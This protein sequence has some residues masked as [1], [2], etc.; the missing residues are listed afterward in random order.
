MK[1]FS[2]ILGLIVLCSCANIGTSSSNKNDIKSFDN[3]SIVTITSNEE[4]NLKLKNILEGYDQLTI[5]KIIDVQIQTYAIGV[6]PGYLK[7]TI[8]SNHKDDIKSIFNF[9]NNTSLVEVSEL[10]G[11]IYGGNALNYIISTSEHIY[12]INT[13]DSYLNINNKYYRIDKSAYLKHGI[14]LKSFQTYANQ[15][16]VYS[17]NT[18]LYTQD[19]LFIDM[20][21]K[22]E[23][24]ISQLSSKFIVNADFG[25]CEVYDS[26]HFSYKTPENK[27]LQCEII[28]GNDFSFLFN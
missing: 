25:D 22:E 3:S 2:L 8:F 6:Q 23:E 1:K 13:T 18:L 9:I 21:F 16:N 7:N 10:E 12:T 14:N 20:Y 26:K 24:G 11:M 27:I 17:E 15:M 28:K 19:N 4:V 5:D